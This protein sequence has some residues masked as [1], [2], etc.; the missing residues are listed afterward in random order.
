MPSAGRHQLHNIV[1]IGHT[2]QAA[3]DEQ[4]YALAEEIHDRLQ[5]EN[6]AT[7]LDTRALSGGVEWA[8]RVELCVSI[9]KVFVCILSTMFLSSYWPMR[10]LDIA[11]NYRS[12]GRIILPVVVGRSQ[13]IYARLQSLEGLAER[14]TAMIQEHRDGVDVQRWSDNLQRLQGFQ[15]ISEDPGSS[16]QFGVIVARVA[17]QVHVYM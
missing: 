2:K 7:F 12:E 3:A 15:T 16:Q 4:P 6:A 5:M 11:L 14:W 1:F 10:E 9:S 17:Q 8:S 13:P